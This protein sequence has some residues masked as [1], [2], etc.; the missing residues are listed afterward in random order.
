MISIIIKILLLFICFSIYLNSVY[1]ICM[2]LKI[3]DSLFNL[4]V[5]DNFKV[6]RVIWSI[7]FNRSSNMLKD[8]HYFVIKVLPVIIMV[9][10]FSII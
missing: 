1:T 4:I 2:R 9:I 6:N 10:A 8:Y 7:I 5:R 3:T